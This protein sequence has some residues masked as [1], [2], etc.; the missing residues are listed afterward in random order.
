MG[1]AGL[2]TP[3]G[4]SDYGS[5][6]ILRFGDG[7]T[8]PV[9]RG[10]IIVAVAHEREAQIE[11]Y[12]LASDDAKGT[13]HLVTEAVYR[14]THMGEFPTDEQAFETFKQ[15]AAMLIAAMEVIERA[16]HVETVALQ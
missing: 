3:N 5:I 2:G 12:P 16:Q 11:K 4:N 6:V 13:N 15:S 8:A 14:L 7:Y 1:F 10:R 9:E